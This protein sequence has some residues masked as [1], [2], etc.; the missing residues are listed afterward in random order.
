MYLPLELGF[1]EDDGGGVE[2]AL[3]PCV[4]GNGAMVVVGSIVVVG[5]Q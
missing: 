2:D 3:L 5:I 4:I 1:A